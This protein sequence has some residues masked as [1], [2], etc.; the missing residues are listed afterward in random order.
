LASDPNA[1]IGIT[2]EIDAEFPHGANDT[3]KRDVVENA[4]S[5]DFKVKDWE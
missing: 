5:L 3:I 2:L 1:T 4:P